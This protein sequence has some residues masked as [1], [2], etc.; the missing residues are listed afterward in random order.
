MHIAGFLL[1]IT[2]HWTLEFIKYINVYTFQTKKRY[3]G[4]MYEST[5]QVSPV[6]LAK[7]I[8]TVRRDGCPAASK[9]NGFYILDKSIFA[10][11]FNYIKDILLR[12]SS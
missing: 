1:G 7:G 8:E 4:Y 10:L 12:F 3:V 11:W 2:C 9:V 5:D 6:F